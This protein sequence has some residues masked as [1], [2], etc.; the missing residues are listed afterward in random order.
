MTVNWTMSQAI[1]LPTLV[2]DSLLVPSPT[3]LAVT[4][5]D[6]GKVSRTIDV[7]RA[8]APKRVD[9]SVVGDRL[10]ELRGALMVAL[11]AS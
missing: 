10:I 5:P 11:K 9:V 7:S 3:G 1:G 8:D 4:S 2:G 6:D